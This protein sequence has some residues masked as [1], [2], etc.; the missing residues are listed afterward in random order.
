MERKTFQ[1]ADFKADSRPG[2]FK[3]RVS[4]FGNVDRGGDRVIEGAF[5]RTLKERGL[6]PIYYSHE[7]ASGP[8][9]ATIDATETKAGLDIEGD[10]YYEDDPFVKRIYRAMKDRVLNEFSFAYDVLKSAV[11]TEDDED[12][13]E[14][15]D[16]DLFEV[17]PTLVGMNPATRPLSIPKGF[18]VAEVRDLEKHGVPLSAPF[19]SFT[20]AGAGSSVVYVSVYLPA[21]E[22]KA[23][24]PE[25]EAS[26]SV[27]QAAEQTENDASENTENA[28]TEG[29]RGAAPFIARPRLH[30][31]D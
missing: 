25:V 21:T 11:V 20:D 5:T 7:W 31:A 27:E 4:V 19:G 16:L 23:N 17:G 30:P 29:E 3:A 1:V 24:T 2:R 18:T 12:I 14:L 28:P 10:L 6:P 22:P 15:H 9:G 26:E 13:R 8:I